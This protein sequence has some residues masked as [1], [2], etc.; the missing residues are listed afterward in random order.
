MARSI[1]R[2]RLL[3]TFKVEDKLFIFSATQPQNLGGGNCSIVAT[4][5]K[6]FPKHFP[7]ETLDDLSRGLVCLHG[8]VIIRGRRTL[9]VCNLVTGEF[10]DLAKVKATDTKR[11]YI[12]YDPFNK[13]F[14]VLFLTSY[15]RQNRVLT[16]ETG[17]PLRMRYTMECEHHAGEYGEVCIDGVLYYEAYFKE[18]ASHMIVCFDFSFEKFSFI[19]TNREMENVSLFNY[20]GKLGAYFQDWH[21]KK[22]RLWVLDDAEK[23]EWSKS[24]Y[25]LSH[26]Y[27]EK[28]GHNSYIVGITSAGEIVFTLVGHLN[29]DF[30]LFFYNME[31]D[32]C[33]RVDIK[34]FEEFKHHNL[35]ITTYLDY[36]ENIMPL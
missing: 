11:S 35:H 10:I 28:I 6:D 31:R 21:S 5:Y 25:V 8:P 34:G 30:Y 2:P 15:G 36:V 24:I 12:G 3:F 22:L 19:E 20:K 17:K 9:I 32:T 26:L 14:K 13:Q 33:T 23:H 18:S 4:R 1:T 7:T 27:S 29:P 16:L